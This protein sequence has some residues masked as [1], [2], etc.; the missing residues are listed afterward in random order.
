MR[1]RV[2]LPN[3]KQNPTCSHFPD[4]LSRSQREC[5]RNRWKRETGRERER[6]RAGRECLNKAIKDN[7]I[8]SRLIPVLLSEQEGTSSFF[9]DLSY[10][11]DVTFASVRTMTAR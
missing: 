2:N 3:P 11:A 4:P 6:E 8:G 7:T 9:A 10:E 1:S 5:E